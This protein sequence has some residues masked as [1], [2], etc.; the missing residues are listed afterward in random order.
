[1]LNLTIDI[2]NIEHFF[3][4][5]ATQL[6][7]EYAIC[8]AKSF[9]QITE[10]EFYYN[11]EAQTMDNFAHDHRKKNY[12]NGTW[13]VHGAGIDIVLRDESYYGGILIRGIQQLDTNYQ[14][15][16]QKYIDGPWNSLE[17]LIQEKGLV[18][19]PTSFFL[20]KLPKKKNRSFK[21]SPRVGLNLRKLQDL[22]YICKPWRYNT[23]PI[24]TQN[25]RELLFLQL[26]SNQDKDWHTL[27]LYERTQ[28][29]YLQYFQAGQK[30]TEP[31][32]FIKASKS[33]ENRCQLFGYYLKKYSK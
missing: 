10:L 16:K 28:S 23:T 7:N 17:A 21:K 29:N 9:Y 11:N 24:Q 27:G 18:E 3:D 25:C 1:M 8:V 22:E 26:Y 30:I 19:E 13:R 31:E 32:R 12:E 2:N 6:F 14:P 5:I 33:V 20:Y 4:Q 15:I